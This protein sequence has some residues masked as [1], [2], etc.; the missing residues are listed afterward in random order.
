MSKIIKKSVV[1]IRSDLNTVGGG[2]RVTVNLCN[3]LFPY[4]NTYLVNNYPN[5]SAYDILPDIQTVYLTKRKR[6]LRYTFI[7]S[8][9][10]LRMLLK[11]KHIDAIVCVGM[12][13]VLETFF[14]CFCLNTQ[15][16]FYEQSTL[17]KFLPSNN[18]KKYSTKK[19]AFSH[20]QQWIINHFFDKILVLTQKEK[21]NYINKFNIKNDKIAVIPNFLD[22]KL[23]KTP[24][25][26][27]SQSKKIITV[28]RI[29]YAKGY[30]ILI[31]V[32]QIVLKN[33]PDWQWHIYGEGDIEYSR[34]IQNLID[35]SSL[36]NKVILKGTRKNIY[37]IYPEYALQVVTS[38]YEGFS[39]VLLEG[40]ANSLPAISFDIYSGPSDL[41]MNGINGYLIPPGDINEMANKINELIKNEQKRIDFSQH[42][43]DNIDKF[44]KNN[45]I[46]KWVA[47]LK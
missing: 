16:Y 39:M 36:K 23:E 19:K 42:A 11:E 10:Q 1:F 37:N 15:K 3:S 33:N 20:F 34:Y 35:E 28:G 40:K 5:K 26:Y 14:A 2:E 43:R 6:K 41:I 25:H 47:L 45:V 27:N 21:N 4:F 44:I 24:Y 8:V 38:R 17:N 12:T 13:D 7:P 9:I 22:E 18:T 29:D 31:K 46:L 32:A 30:E